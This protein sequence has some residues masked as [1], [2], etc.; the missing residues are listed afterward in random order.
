MACGTPILGLNNAMLRDVVVPGVTGALY[1]GSEEGL[2]HATA[3]LLK[4]KQQL[5]IWGDNCREF[6]SKNML[7]SSNIER[8]TALFKPYS[9]YF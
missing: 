8:L 2:G 9:S 4:N 7:L 3:D 6:I 1:Y 5:R